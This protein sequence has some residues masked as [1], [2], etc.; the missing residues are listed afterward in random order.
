MYSFSRASLCIYGSSDEGVVGLSYTSNF[1][2]FICW[3]YSI[4]Y[5]YL[6]YSYNRLSYWLN[7]HNYLILCNK[8]TF[9]SLSL[10]CNLFTTIIINLLIPLSI[11]TFLFVLCYLLLTFSVGQWTYLFSMMLISYLHRGVVPV[12]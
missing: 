6:L 12:Q 3:W 7:I 11:T 8:S 5:I 4:F 9:Y 10:V 2:Y 1:G